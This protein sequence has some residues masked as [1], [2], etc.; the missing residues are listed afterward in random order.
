MANQQRNVLNKQSSSWQNVTSGVPQS[1]VLGPLLF[2]IYINHLLN[3]IGLSGIKLADY[4]FLKNRY[5]TNRKIQ[6]LI[7]IRKY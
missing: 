4:T 1:S 5:H 2:L 6:F 7:Q 3:G